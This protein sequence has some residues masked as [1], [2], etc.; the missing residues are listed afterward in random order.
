MLLGA[1]KFGDGKQYKDS[2]IKGRSRRRRKKTETVYSDI[3]WTAFCILFLSRTTDN[4]EFKRCVV[5]GLCYA[6]GGCSITNDDHEP[7]VSDFVCGT[8]HVETV[9]FYYT[10]Y[11]AYMAL[12]NGSFCS[13]MLVVAVRI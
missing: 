8:S 2:Y 6:N 13:R 9:S 1:D 12:R 7:A 3:F 10:A 11:K 4:A 5:L